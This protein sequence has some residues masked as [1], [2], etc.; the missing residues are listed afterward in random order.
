[1]WRSP[2]RRAWALSQNLKEKK[3]FNIS[4]NTRKNRTAT[5]YKKKVTTVSRYYT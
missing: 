5:C 4:Y 1:V 3:L 2:C